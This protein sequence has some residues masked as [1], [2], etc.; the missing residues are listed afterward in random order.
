MKCW[1]TS[2]IEYNFSINYGCTTFKIRPTGHS[3]HAFTGWRTVHQPCQVFVSS[4]SSKSFKIIQNP[5][6]NFKIILSSLPGLCLFNVIT[7]ATNQLQQVIPSSWPASL[8]VVCTFIFSLSFSDWTSES[9]LE[10]RQSLRWDKTY[11]YLMKA[12]QN[13][14]GI[15]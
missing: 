14:P 2:I 15:P 1:D 11:H 10:I 4:I 7:I 9:M 13:H 12:W 6:K 3:I 5:S 8:Y